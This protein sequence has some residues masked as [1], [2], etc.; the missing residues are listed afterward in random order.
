MSTVNCAHYGILYGGFFWVNFQNYI[1]GVHCAFLVSSSVLST[2]H[3]ITQHTPADTFQITKPGTPTSPLPR[4]SPWSK[5]KARSTS[6]TTSNNCKSDADKQSQTTPPPQHSPQIKTLARTSENSESD[7]D[8]RCPP[9]RA[10]RGKKKTCTTSGNTELD[11]DGPRK[12]EKINNKWQHAKTP[13]AGQKKFANYS[14]NEDYLI[15][16]AIVH[17]TID[18]IRGVGQKSETFWTRAHEKFCLWQ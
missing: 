5:T 15:A 7:A 2:T 8:K 1:W 17:V 12:K 10:P 11:A 13:A 9:R 14:E 6:T 3:L 18:P 16:M 4:R